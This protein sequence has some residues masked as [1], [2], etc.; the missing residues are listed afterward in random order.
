MVSDQKLLSHRKAV[1]DYFEATAHY[2]EELYDRQDRFYRQRHERVLQFT[3][4]LGLPPESGLLEI[5][6]GP[7]LTAVALARRGYVVH[8]IDIAPVMIDRTLQ[9]AAAAGVED[10]VWARQADIQALT[11]GDRM[12]DLVLAVGVIPWVFSPQR[13]L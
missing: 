7:G 12:F 1:G 6:C 8:A 3:D 11:F 4:K 13:A 10:R 9:R 2:W 5:G